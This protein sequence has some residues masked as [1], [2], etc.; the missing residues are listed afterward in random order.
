MIQV[1]RFRPNTCNCDLLVEFDDAVPPETRIHSLRE[2]IVRD[3]PHA[4]ILDA[5]LLST[6]HEETSRQS[7]TQTTVEAA[8][9]ELTESFS[10]SWTEGRTLIVELTGVP[11]G[12]KNA[13]QAAIDTLIGPGKVVVQ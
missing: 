1:Q 3:A 10:M 12:R 8:I 6:V 5:S 7:R 2:V 4:A 13:L 9:D 11:Q